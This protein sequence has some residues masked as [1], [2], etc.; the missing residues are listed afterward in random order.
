MVFQKMIERGKL[1]IVFLLVAVVVGVLT[2]FQ[3]PKREIPE[4]SVNII[5]IQTPYPGATAETVERNVTNI[6]ETELRGLDGIEKV[7]SLSA[8]EFSNITVEYEDG[9]DKS[10]LQSNVRQAISDAAPRL[11]DN[12][13]APTVND[14]IGQLPV[15]SYLLTSTDR[16]TLQTV[17][18][19]VERLEERLLRTDGVTGVTIKGLPETEFVVSL[20]SAELGERQLAF[21]DVLTAINEEYRTTPLGRQSTEEGIY[22]LAIDSLTNVNDMGQVVVGSVNGTPVLLEDVGTVEETPKAVTDLVS[23]DGQPAISLTVTIE[24]GQDIPTLQERVDEVVAAEVGDVSG[25][26]L[27]SYYEQAKAVDDIFSALTKEFIVAMIAVIVVTT[28][29]LTF[30]GSL[31][32]SLAIPLSFLLAL[33]PLRFTG[34]DLNQISIIGAIIALGI[35]VDDA[36]V[37]NDNIL[38]R[39]RKGDTAMGGAVR[40]TKEVWGSIVT[41]TLA[42]VFAFLPLTL[43]S[44]ANGN[45]IRALPTVLALSVLASMI[46]SLTLVP[47]A[48]YWLNR[49]QVKVSKRE[50]GWLGGPLNRLSN[51]YA[52]KLLPV[53]AK[54]PWTFGLVGFVVTTALY[55]LIVLTPFEFFPAANRPEVVTSVTFPVQ[56]DLEETERR[57]REIEAEFQSI[58]G[59]TET[60]IFAGSGLPSI[61]TGGLDQTGENTGQIVVRVDNETID[62][63]QLIDDYTTQIRESNPDAE[64]FLDTQQ[65]GPPTSAPVE[66]TM[67]G[68]TIEQLVAARDVVKANLEEIEGALVLDNIKEP[69]QTLTYK[70]D[71][72]AMAAAGVTAKT[73]SDQIRLV[74]DGIPIGTFDDGVEQRDVKIVVDAEANREALALDE[75]LVPVQTEAG[76]PV[77]PL[78]TFVTETKTEQI[79]QIPREN[80][81]RTVTLQIF[82]SEGMDEDAFKEDVDRVLSDA[83]ASLTD[84]GIAFDQS[85]AS[86]TQNEFFL[87]LATLFVVVLFLIF[88]IIAFQFNSLSLP[89]LVLFTIYLAIAGAVVGLFITQTPFSFMASMGIV[90]LAGIVV[91]NAVVLFEFIEQGIRDGMAVTTAVYEAGRARIRPILLTALTAVVALLPV[92]FGQDPLFKPLAICIVS[93]ILFSTILT[94]VLVPAYYL[95]LAKRRHRDK[96]F[97]E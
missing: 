42:V 38:R 73:V 72:D 25:V 45:F 1:V 59:V 19:D 51:F 11:P 46:I 44:G 22:Q 64:I 90:S 21:P 36:I 32:V 80:G 57:L 34:V 31:I 96:P 70:L 65:Q 50:P 67:R 77:A 89:L 88:L 58:D 12:A 53:V 7:S 9:F 68:E 54:R 37:V 2:F 61:F 47:I 33:I 56:T 83:E 24:S 81:E 92:A 79:Q 35:L 86:D 28:I 76:P 63:I 39:Y 30:S 41:S 87:E 84:E 69:F 18:E 97:T 43:L 91:R 78:S 66:F 60:S 16:E 55:G 75:I 5:L 17:R 62:A 3:L 40:G 94:L 82:A 15:A 52:D 10:E 4:T 93:G 85:G 26:E 27:V 23:L 8:S 20:D 6:L 95:I 49:K 71:R 13:L 74:T 14:S 29:G 48:Q